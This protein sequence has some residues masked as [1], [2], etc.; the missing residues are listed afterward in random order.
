MPN[1]HPRADKVRRSRVNDAAGRFES[2]LLGDMIRDRLL[3][4]DGPLVQLAS[5][6]EECYG[7]EEHDVPLTGEMQSACFAAAEEI[8][9][10]L[11]AE[12]ER[13]VLHVLDDIVDDS[14]EVID[15]HGDDGQAAVA[16]A[17]HYIAIAGL[18]SKDDADTEEVVA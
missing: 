10:A 18:P 15:H 12:V 11:E 16:E 5:A 17:R 8:H 13:Q 14:G 7:L 9:D 1:F 6:M 4:D 3:Y 2:S